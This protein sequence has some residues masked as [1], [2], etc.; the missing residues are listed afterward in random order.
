M[1]E[2]FALAPNPLA[3][4]ERGESGEAMLHIWDAPFVG[5]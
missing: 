4:W 1:P 2:I 5:R 3:N